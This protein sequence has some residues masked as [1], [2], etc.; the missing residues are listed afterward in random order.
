MNANLSSASAVTSVTSPVT[1]TNL[2]GMTRE[3]METFFLSIGE[4]KFRAQQVIKWI[5]QIGVDDFEQMTNVS[6]ALRQKL[7][8]IAEIRG[9]GGDSPGIFCRRHP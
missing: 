7:A 2:L 4:K 5:H 6:K 8:E 1:K 3:Q 9:A